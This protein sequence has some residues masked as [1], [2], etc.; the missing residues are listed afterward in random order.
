MGESMWHLCLDHLPD[1]FFLEGM[2]RISLRDAIFREVASNILIH[3]EYTNAF[4]AKLIIERG[5][6]RTENSNKPHG[7]G[8]LD[9]A[10]FTPFPKNPVIGAFFREIHRADEL[11]SGMRKLMRYGKAYGGADPEMIE[12]DVFRI[13]VKVPEF[14]ATGEESGIPEVTPQV[15]PHVAPQ[16]ERLLRVVKGEVDRDALQQAVGLKARKNFRQLYLAPAI[17]AGLIEM[18]IPDKPRSSKQKYR[19]TEKG[20]KMLKGIEGGNQ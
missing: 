11:G 17:D 9:P 15:T 14:G 20:R 12:G 1:P 6:V 7:F 2:E 13:N 19:L 18:T 10:T 5:Q 3:R 8:V 16:V 4:P